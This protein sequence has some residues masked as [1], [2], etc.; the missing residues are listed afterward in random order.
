MGRFYKTGLI[1]LCLLFGGCDRPPPD[2]IPS[3]AASSASV[4]DYH[5]DSSNI[6]SQHDIA[7]VVD[8]IPNLS[9][10][11]ADSGL[12]VERVE[13]GQYTGEDIKNSDGMYQQGDVS[14]NFY[15]NEPSSNLPC[16]LTAFFTVDKRGS[17]WLARTKTANF[18]M[19]G[20]CASPP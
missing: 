5:D 9:Q 14:Y 17:Q 8:S 3:V 11:L 2:N 20:E 15:T 13:F 16:P 1:G 19:T 4:Q 7:S 6:E 18:L 10:G 12:A